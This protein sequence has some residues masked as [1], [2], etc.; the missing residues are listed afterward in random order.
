MDYQS[1]DDDIYEPDQDSSDE[2]MPDQQ[3]PGPSNQSEA[4]R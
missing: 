4:R 1:S 3:D 2:E